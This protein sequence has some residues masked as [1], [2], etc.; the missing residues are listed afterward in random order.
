MLVKVS[1][2]RADSMPH[3]YDEAEAAKHPESVEEEWAEFF[4]TWRSRHLELYED[5]VRIFH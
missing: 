3:P 4:V 2:N 5:W 1:H